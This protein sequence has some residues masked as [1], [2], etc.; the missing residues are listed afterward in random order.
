MKKL[1]LSFLTSCFLLPLV[2]L[3]QSVGVNTATPDASAILDVKSTTKGMLIPR[4]STIARTGIA[5]P[6]KGLIVYDTTTSSFWFHNG[7]AW[8]EISGGGNAWKLTGNAGT[9]AA[10]NFIGTTDN[11]SLRFKVNNNYAGEINAS[12]NN[13][14]FGIGAASSITTGNHNVSLGTAAMRSVTTGSYIVAIGD[15]A[16]YSQVANG[17]PEYPNFAVGSRA[18]FANTSGFANTYAG[19]DAG[20]KNT[21]GSGNT[22][23]GYEAGYSNVNGSTNSF[24]GRGAGYSLNA[25]GRNSFFGKDAG[26]FSSGNDNSFFGTQAGEYNSTGSN[27]SFYGVYAGR[28]N[29]TGSFNCLFGNYTG[30][31]NNT[32]GNNNSIFGTFAGYSM[33]A[34]SNN[35]LF[36]NGAGYV[37]VS[38]YSNVGIGINAMRLNNSG[39]NIVAVGDSSLYNTTSSNNTAVG[40]KA[41]YANTNAGENTYVGFEAGVEAMANSNSFFGSKSGWHTTSGNHS[42]YIGYLAGSGITEG[43]A[44]TFVG[45]TANG[46]VNSLHNAASLGYSALVS[47]NNCLALGGTTVNNS[48]TRVGIN[49]T[50]PLTDLHIIQQTDAG[51]DKV[52][53]L[54]LQRSSNTNHWR[55]MI[56]PSNNLIFEYNDVGYSYINPTTL[57]FVQGSDEKLKKDI[58]P[59]AGM[60]DKVMRLQAKSYHYKAN[61][62]NDPLS[63]GFIAQDVQKIFPEF[64]SEN[65]NNGLLGLSYSSF[66]VVAIKAIQEQQQVIDNQSRRIEE[67]EKKLEKVLDALQTAKK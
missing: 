43:Y 54:R 48:A 3:A 50:T 10:N 49:N 63:F 20:Y 16:L 9:N 61:S 35:C 23:V 21:I 19:N 52:R 4:T 60:L 26:Y 27:N 65:A 15:S 42:T 44:N 30:V 33:G 34:G 8:N 47:C 40:S 67:L 12:S 59:L 36:G 31:F 64:V 22:F 45:S 13:V 14:G 7:S 55:I 29:S 53:G 62:Q 5:S 57:A 37:N 39:H 51:G 56:D 11:Q 2:L 17:A 41:G 66:G 18:G 58:V 25:G 24:F 28:N 1:V 46:T 38:G 6:A 32:T